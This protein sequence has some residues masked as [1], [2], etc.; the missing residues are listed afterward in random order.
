[1]LPGKCLASPQRL[2]AIEEAETDLKA[3]PSAPDSAVA[4]I[5]NRKGSGHLFF[6]GAAPRTSTGVVCCFAVDPPKEFP[7][8][9]RRLSTYLLLQSPR[10]RRTASGLRHSRLRKQERWRCAHGITWHRRRPHGGYYDPG[11]D[12]TYDD[13]QAL[14]ERKY[15]RQVFASLFTL[16]RGV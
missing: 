16:R 13:R 7:S 5:G 1:M 15:D 2:Q 4:T 6:P 10:A 14:P 9:A 3:E 8:P 12:G 11:E